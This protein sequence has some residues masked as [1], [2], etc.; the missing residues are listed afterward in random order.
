MP[1]AGRLEDLIDQRDALGKIAVLIRNGSI[2]QRIMQAA[3]AITR[4]CA[5]RDDLC[6]LES[7]FD[8]VRNGSSR[9]PW[10]RAGVRYVA[11]SYSFDTFHGVGSLITLCESGA[12]AFDCDDTTILIGS[13]AAALGF[14]VG[15]RAWGQSKKQDGEYQHVYAVACVPKAGPWPRNYFGHGLDTTVP[16]AAVGWEPEGGHIMTAWIE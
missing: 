8:A 4:G 2:D 12:C 14:K 16:E 7:L 9:V 3:K 10:L 5:A 11:D 15:A 1:V 6:E 13:L